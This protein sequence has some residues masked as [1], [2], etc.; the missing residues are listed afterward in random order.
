MY[1]LFSIDNYLYLR[2]FWIVQSANNILHFRFS[3]CG[4]IGRIFVGNLYLIWQLEEKSCSFVPLLSPFG[5]V[6]GKAPAPELVQELAHA[7]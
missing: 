2:L 6:A 5:I 4:V 1:S 7:D 3:E